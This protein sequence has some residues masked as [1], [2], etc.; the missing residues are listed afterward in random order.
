MT[1]SGSLEPNLASLR[2]SQLLAGRPFGL[3]QVAAG[4]TAHCFASANA[5]VIQRRRQTGGK[6]RKS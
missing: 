6:S 5:A 4:V 2:Q 3:L 1:P